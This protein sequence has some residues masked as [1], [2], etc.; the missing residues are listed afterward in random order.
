MHSQLVKSKG[1]AKTTRAAHVYLRDTLTTETE[2]RNDPIVHKHRKHTQPRVCGTWKPWTGKPWKLYC[3]L[4]SMQCA[5]LSFLLP[6]PIRFGP[7]SIWFLPLPAL[8]LMNSICFGSLAALAR[9]LCQPTNC[10]AL[11]ASVNFISRP[12]N[13]ICLCVAFLFFSFSD[14]ACVLLVFLSHFPFSIA[15]ISSIQWLVVYTFPGRTRL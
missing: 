9:I 5:F 12:I 15:H 10:R 7:K 8:C 4:C 2:I 13:A 11:M 1:V 6:L 14:S 3:N